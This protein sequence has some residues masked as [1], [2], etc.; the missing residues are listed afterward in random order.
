MAALKQKQESRK[1]L[2]LQKTYVSGGQC[3]M[4]RAAALYLKPQLLQVKYAVDVYAA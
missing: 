4:V 3:N 2:C 1:Q